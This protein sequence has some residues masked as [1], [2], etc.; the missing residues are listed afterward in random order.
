MAKIGFD[1]DAYTARLIGRENVSRLESAI[2]ELVKNTYD[3]DATCCILYYEAE[4]DTLY[5][6]DN[7]SGMSTDVIK[8]HWM[9]IGNSSKK[10]NYV[11]KKGRVQTGAK[12]IGRFALDRIGDNC[13]MHTKSTT[14]NLEWSVDWSLFKDGTP[15]TNISADL[16]D[17]EYSFDEF[18]S[19]A[20]SD[21]FKKLVKEKFENTGTIFKI[22][23]VRDEWNAKLIGKL[24]NNLA[25]LVPQE[26]SSIFSIYFFEV[27]TAIDDAQLIMPDSN[28]V[29]DYKISFDVKGDKVKLSI[30][31][32]EFDFKTS[33]DTIV[34]GAGFSEEDKKYFVGTPIEDELS[35][36]TLMSSKKTTITNTIGDF[37]GMFLFAKI[38][39]QEEDKQ[40]Y[41][42]KNDKQVSLPWKGIRIYRDNFRVRPYGDHDTSAY[43]WLLLANRKAKS[44]AAPSHQDGKWRVNADQIC[45]TILISRTN[46]TLP[47]Q[48]NR[49]GFVET[50]EFS[51]L[52]SFLARIIQKFEEDRQ[53]VFRKLSKYYDATHP[54]AQFEKEIHDKA[55][56]K[57]AEQPQDHVADDGNASALSVPAESTHV[58]AAK[59]HAVI[60]HKDAQIQSLENELQLLR[61]LGTIGILTNTY[62]HEIRG[63]TNNLGLKIV[64]A[65]EALEYDEDIPE[66]LRNISEAIAYQ[67]SF[68]SWFKVTIETVRKDRRTMKNVNLRDLMIEL[69]NSWNDTCKDITIDLDCES[70][71]FRCFTYEIESIINNLIANSTTAFKS[72]GQKDKRITISISADEE[73]IVISYRDNG[74]GL[75]DKYKTDPDKIM[76]AMET[77][78]T[79]LDGEIIGTGMGMWII[80]KTVVEY[81]G[82]VDL[83]ENVRSENGFYAKI[84]LKG[85][86]IS[87]ND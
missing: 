86:R 35:F 21:D 36:T 41:Y 60:K 47:D 44:P 24:K 73:G 18:V 10:R 58:E 28:G 78:K 53:G 26:I 22:S 66:A 6:A 4:T 55:Q 19:S 7:G 71:E 5:I 77:D 59:A 64:M 29:Y 37:S 38:Q 13:V 20:I 49:E 76:E 8:K 61:A 87:S 32:N 85:R 82:N 52:K 67:E 12:G 56:N 30:I 74:P 63:N 68:G 62:V 83:S 65:K 2:L 69:K 33:F 70:V 23:P 31:R 39:Y 42:Y 14:E 54:V 79:D 84:T 16:V 46:I 9:T 72:T 27:N 11:S 40:K 17:V 51:I 3:A 75:S 15:L 25:T 43:D 45:G 48:A 81:N 50:P 34:E 1:V 80:G 57:G